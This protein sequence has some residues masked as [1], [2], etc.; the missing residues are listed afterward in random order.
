MSAAPL[1]SRGWYLPARARK[2]HY[3]DDGRALCGRWGY[4]GS[5]FLTR[6][7]PDIQC[8]ACAGKLS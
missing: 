2:H 8:K 7:D 6:P 5:L 3:F 4:F 1:K